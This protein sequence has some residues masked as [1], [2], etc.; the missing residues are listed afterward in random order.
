MAKETSDTEGDT[1][2]QRE[3]AAIELI[4]AGDAKLQVWTV[5]DSDPSW[6]KTLNQLAIKV[7]IVVRDIQELQRLQ[8]YCPLLYWRRRRFV[9]YRQRRP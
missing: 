1:A 5:H 7:Y 8:S 6:S 4:T 9:A 2:E 3:K